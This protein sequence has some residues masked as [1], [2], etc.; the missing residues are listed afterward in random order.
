ML[1]DLSA[2]FDTVDHGT[3]LEVL[4][5]RFGITGSVL[6]WFKFYLTGRTQTVTISSDTSAAV[7]L[8]CNVPQGS[9]IG[10]LL[11]IAYAGD[12]EKTI[13]IYSV[14]HDLYAEDTQTVITHVYG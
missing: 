8:V 14:E 7:P 11:F 9:M 10:P 3:L 6:E 4:S 5:L 1:L 12:L 2:A 13:D